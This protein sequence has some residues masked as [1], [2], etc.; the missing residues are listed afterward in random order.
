VNAP[1]TGIRTIYRGIMFRSRTEAT[2]A[3]FFDKLLWRWDYEPI[4]L[5]RYIPDFVLAFAKPTLLEVKGVT[6]LEE[7]ELHR[8]KITRSS[9]EGEAILVGAAPFDIE[10]S[11]PILG[12]IGERVL[13]AGELEWSWGQARLFVC[14]SCGSTSVLAEDGDWR[15]RI[16]GVDGGNAHILPVE[17]SVS[18]EWTLAKNQLQWRPGT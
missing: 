2:W 5:N 10:S 7:L 15:C 11:G 17:D 6:T 3:C 8:E 4:D 16:C 14:S 9:W 18:R 13:I 1:P 12:L